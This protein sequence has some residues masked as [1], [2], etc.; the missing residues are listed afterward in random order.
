MQTTRPHLSAPVTQRPADQIGMLVTDLDASMQMWMNMGVGPWT[1]FRNVRMQ[2]SYCGQ[3]TQVHMDAAMSYQGNVQLELIQWRAGTLCP[4]V[5]INGEPL[6]G[7]HHMAWLVDDLQAAVAQAEATG[8]RCVFE[9]SNPS[10][11]VAYVEMAPAGAG[12]AVMLEFIESAVTRALIAQGI[13]ATQ[14]WDGSRHVHTIDLDAS[15]PSTPA[16]APPAVTA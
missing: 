11:K 6:R 16:T 15:A 8:G 7:L 2:G 14:R 3:P 1:V 10:T 4:Y 5:D 9:A 13:E 12:D